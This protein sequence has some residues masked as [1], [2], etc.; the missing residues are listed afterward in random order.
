MRRALAL[1]RAA[2]ELAGDKL[3]RAD[4]SLRPRVPPMPLS[5]CTLRH[6]RSAPDSKTPHALDESDCHAGGRRLRQAVKSLPGIAR[7][8]ALISAGWQIFFGFHGVARR[9]GTA[10]SSRRCEPRMPSSPAEG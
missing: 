9:D 5:P 6:G 2:P 4:A 1:P 7:A 10:R 8:I 3:S